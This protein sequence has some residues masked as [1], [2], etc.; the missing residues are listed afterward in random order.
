MNN[1]PEDM[2]PSP[3][4]TLSE[5]LNKLKNKGY[6]NELLLSDH[7][8]M[9]GMD[10]VYTPDDLTIIKTYRFEGFSDPADN[11]ALYLVQDKDQAIGYIMDVYGSNSDHTGPAFDDF[12]KQIPVSD[13]ETDW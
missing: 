5:V 13:S 12:L 2:M 10:K 6:D 7:G 9:Q 4:R 1:E 8:K 3:M 11:T